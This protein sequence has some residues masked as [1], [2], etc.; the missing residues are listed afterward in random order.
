MH[1]TEVELSAFSFACVSDRSCDRDF[2]AGTDHADK[3]TQDKWTVTVKNESL[4]ASQAR[5]VRAYF[6]VSSKDRGIGC[7]DLGN[8]I[9]IGF[10]ILPLTLDQAAP[11]LTSFIVCGL[12]GRVKKKK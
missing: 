9:L 11:Q 12:S 6:E 1:S 8:F 4:T 7:L 3:A 5:M 10:T 2:E